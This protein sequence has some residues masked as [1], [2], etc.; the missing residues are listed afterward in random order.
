MVVYLNYHSY[1]A[2]NSLLNEGDGLMTICPKCKAKIYIDESE[3]ANMTD[4][5]RK[6]WG[7][8]PAYTSPKQKDTVSKVIEILENN[9]LTFSEAQRILTLANYALGNLAI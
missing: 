3:I 7:I 5:E 2:T 4:E 8:A 1:K 6:E 9:D